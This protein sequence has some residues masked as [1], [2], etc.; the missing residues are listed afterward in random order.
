MKVYITIFFFVSSFKVFGV[1]FSNIDPPLDNGSFE[2]V[3]VETGS[4]IKANEAAPPTNNIDDNSDDDSGDKGGN[5]RPTGGGDKGGN[6]GQG[7]N[8]NN[9]GEDPASNKDEDATSS[10]E[11]VEAQVY[12]ASFCERAAIVLL[13][14][15]GEY[16]ECKQ[17][18]THWDRD[19][20]LRESP[21]TESG[22]QKS[23]EFRPN[24]SDR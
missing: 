3:F 20:Q 18:S 11:E 10:E 15:A 23:D 5:I 1:N 6:I 24:A 9:V 12:D 14:T 4:P 17:Y 2:D 22:A 7:S 19:R 13:S 16:P 21:V 8:V